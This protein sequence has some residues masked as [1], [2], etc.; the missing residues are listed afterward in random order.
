MQ[1]EFNDR[2]SNFCSWTKFK[3]IL[4]WITCCASRYLKGFWRRM[5]CCSSEH[6]S[7]IWSC[8]KILQLSLTFFFTSR[9]IFDVMNFFDLYSITSEPCQDSVLVPKVFLL[10]INDLLPFTSNYI[11]SYT[12]DDTLHWNIQFLKRWQHKVHFLSTWFALHSGINA[13]I[14]VQFN[15][16]KTQLCTL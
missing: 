10:H 11:H 13:K 5:A 6:I 7:F 12:D 4:R 16:F 15:D 8:F 1:N 3:R 9:I 2:T 14:F